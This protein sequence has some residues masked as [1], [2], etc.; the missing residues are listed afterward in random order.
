MLTAAYLIN[1]LPSKPLGFKT[2]LDILCQSFPKTVFPS[3]ISPEIFGCV[4]YIHN[5]SPSCTKLDPKAIKC[6]FIRYSFSQK[7]YKCYCPNTRKIFVTTD[8]TFYE[9]LPFYQSS[10][11]PTINQPSP[12]QLL[13]IDHLLPVCSQGGELPPENVL[14]QQSQSS[15][16]FSFLPGCPSSPMLNTTIFPK[17]MSCSGVDNPPPSLRAD[18]P[19]LV[20]LIH[21]QSQHY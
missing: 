6:I 2:P 8:A 18:D 9:D 19:L 17:P 7:G 14:A 11:H 20:Y 21:P 13:S 16:S 3:S 1:R 5:H 4:V 12:S 10:G 15:S